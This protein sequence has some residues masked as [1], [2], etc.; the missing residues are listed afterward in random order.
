MHHPV[1]TN[2][3]NTHKSQMKW[4]RSSRVKIL[5]AKGKPSSRTCCSGKENITILAGA[6]AAGEKIS[7]LVIFKGSHV[8][9]S[10]ISHKNK[11][12]FKDM[13]FAV[14]PNGWMQLFTMFFFHLMLLTGTYSPNIWWTCFSYRQY[15][16]WTCMKFKY[17]YFKIFCCHLTKDRTIRAT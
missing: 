15:I 7:P 11:E 4:T 6:G 2:Q 5:G 12:I 17:F 8:W 1:D 13:T 10:W 3:I 14:S 9:S 16:S